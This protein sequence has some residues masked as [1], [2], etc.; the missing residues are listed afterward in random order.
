MDFLL[1]KAHAL[2]SK[3]RYMSYDDFLRLF[4]AKGNLVVGRWSPGD[5]LITIDPEAGTTEVEKFKG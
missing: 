2:I 5:V 4:H 1:R 3:R